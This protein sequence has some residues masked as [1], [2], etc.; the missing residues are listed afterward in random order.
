VIEELIAANERYA[1]GF[2]LHDLPRPPGRHLAV[3]TCMDARIDRAAIG[4]E[5]GDANWI[6][7]AGGIV[8]D[9]VLRSLVVS[10]GLLG[11]RELLVLGHTDC[12]LAGLDEDE[13]R[14][15]LGVEFPLHAFDDLEAR[16]AESVRIVR[17]CPFLDLETAG[18]VYD[19]FTG[20][21][22]LVA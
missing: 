10:Q 14:R 7:N 16:V 2:R 1:A 9:D 13:T 17:E 8:T 11:V 4:I 18:A 20:R 12:G 22:R 5:P 19:V 21:V 15:R 6:G 3:V